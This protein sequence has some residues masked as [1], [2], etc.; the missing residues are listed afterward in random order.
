M[1]LS[2][3]HIIPSLPYYLTADLWRIEALKQIDLATTES[4]ADLL[5][6]TTQGDWTYDVEKRD[7]S[8]WF[9]E[10]EEEHETTQKEDTSEPTESSTTTETTPKVTQAT[11]QTIAK[12][13]DFNNI[14]HDWWDYRG[15][16]QGVS[17]PDGKAYADYLQDKRIIWNKPYIRFVRF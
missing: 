9:D 6:P 2:A 1:L 17:S 4:D 11:Q 13:Y 8:S 10:S 5:S 14:T 3:L 12:I 7:V 16:L 15:K